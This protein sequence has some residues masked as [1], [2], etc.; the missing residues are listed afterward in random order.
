[1]FSCKDVIYNPHISLQSTAAEQQQY[2]EEM[3]YV[4]SQIL[5]KY[6]I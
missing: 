6:Y 4:V 5:E 2:T 3:E 1:M